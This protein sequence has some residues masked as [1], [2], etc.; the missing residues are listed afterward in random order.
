MTRVPHIWVL[1]YPTSSSSTLVRSLTGDITSEDVKMAFLNV[2]MGYKTWCPFEEDAINAS[3]KIEMVLDC[4]AAKYDNDHVAF[5]KK[6]FNQNWAGNAMQVSPNG[7]TNAIISVQL[8]SFPAEAAE[9]KKETLVLHP[10][11]VAGY[12][13]S[14]TLTIQHPGELRQEAEAKK[15]VAKLMLLCL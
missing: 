7:H 10:V 3:C 14:G 15:G 6:Y 4:V 8:D 13:G 11:F 9:I 1:S 2:S 5:V 12:P